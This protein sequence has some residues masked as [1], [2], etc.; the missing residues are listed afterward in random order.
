MHKIKEV[1]ISEL[2]GY[3]TINTIVILSGVYKQELAEIN[4]QI[5]ELKQQ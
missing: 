4:R 1:A 5:Q 3:Y 2:A